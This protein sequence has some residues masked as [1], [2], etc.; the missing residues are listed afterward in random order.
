MPHLRAVLTLCAAL[1]A[2]P[3]AAQSM[4]VS[5]ALD[6]TPNTN[7]I[8]LFVA[9]AKGFYEE[10]GLDVEI[11][12]YS[13][14]SAA[15]LVANNI[16]DFGVLGSIGLFTQRTAGADLVATY[17]LVQTETGRLVFRADR[18]DIQTPRD[19]DGKIYAGFGS[20]WET[21]MIGT[22]IR[23]DGGEGAFETV[24]L[25]TSAYEALANGAVDF[26]LE[27]YT[28]EGVKAE[29]DG[30]AQRAFRYANYG[31]PDQ[32]TNFLGT[33]GAYLAEHPD[34]A[35]AFISTSRRGYAYAVEYPEEAADILV[36]ANADT[37][38]DREF[39]RA[40]LQAM[41][42]GH[43]LRAEDGTIGTIDPGKMEAMGG[44]L[45]EA[46]LLK[47]GSGATVGEKPDFSTYYTN[48]LLGMEP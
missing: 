1:I 46:G 12:P 21:A 2:T 23:H 42:D 27:V 5:V 7:H 4:P 41:I 25:G 16:A 8:G 9:E 40:S 10:A 17:A 38:L 20:G 45:F 34:T 13:D 43:Y 35:R 14:T 19:L 28:W 26:T 15:V 3:A 24:T 6:W 32:H 11:L 22:I 47:D 31:V 18:D 37:L 36:A 44:F 33:T 39:V 30:P 29:R 48:D